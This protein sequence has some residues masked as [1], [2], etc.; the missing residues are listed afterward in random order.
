MLQKDRGGLG[1]ARV[2]LREAAGSHAWCWRR[3]FQKGAAAATSRA[4]AGW[5]NA[6]GRCVDVGLRSCHR[7]RGLD[8]LGG[9][10]RGQARQVCCRGPR[11]R[12]QSQQPN[13][14]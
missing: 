13:L 7:T 1:E 11:R 9:D 6:P 10:E 8:V 2:A 12:D 5:S 3:A 4:S 14:Q